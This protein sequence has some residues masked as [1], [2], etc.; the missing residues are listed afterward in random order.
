[1]IKGEINSIKN[2]FLLKNYTTPMKRILSVLTLLLFITACDDGD[3]TVDVIDFSEAPAQKCPVKDVI[4]KVKDSEMLFIEIPS[5][6]FTEN[7]TLPDAPI[8]VALS[9][10]VKV[11]YRKYDDTVTSLNICPTVPDG[12]PNV[13]EQW[14]ATSGIIQ[15]KATSIKTTN[16]TTG[17]TKI[18]G[19]IYN[20]TFKNITFEK[21]SG[22]QVYETFAFGNYTTTISALAFGFDDQAEKS[23]CSSDNR[24]FNF[25]GSEVLILDVGANYP[26]LFA[27]AVTS[28]PRTAL[29]NPTNK[30]TYKLFT[31][32][33][34]NAYF[35]AT[36]PPAT[37]TLAQE[38]NAVDGVE[39]V[40]G[41]IEV[42]TTTFGSDFQHTVHLK[43]VVLKKGNS[44][45]TLGN[46]YIY[47][48][49]VTP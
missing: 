26:A 22:P 21:P 42:S 47:G 44:T 3:L 41:I 49:F 35:C 23:T 36:T 9:S 10:T 13:V 7:E 29:I 2:L 25:A 33:V 32:T 4:Y 18:T 38:W 12:T 20:I 48:S 45:F 17:A 19:Y 6:Y 5:S 28:T 14:D 46:D 31:N 37:P 40:S 43:N 15:I 16:T 27:S 8:E 39:A 1:M 34:D 11:T 24:I 30:L